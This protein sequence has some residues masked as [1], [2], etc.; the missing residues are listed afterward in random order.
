MIN[1]FNSNAYC[2]LILRRF[3]VY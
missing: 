3:S 2:I 1:K